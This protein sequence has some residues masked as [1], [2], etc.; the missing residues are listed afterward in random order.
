MLRRHLRLLPAVTAVLAAVAARPDPL[1]AQETAEKAAAVD[2]LLPGDVIRLR[3][4]REPDLTGEFPIA[5][6]GI[7]VLPKLGPLRATGQPPAALERKI[8]E[9]YGRYLRNPSIDVVFLRRI[10][11][12]G[13]VRQPGLF[14]VDPTMTVGDAL[15]LAGGATP[16]GK[17]DEIELLRGGEKVTVDIDE[18]TRISDL[19]IRSGDQLYVPERSWF[20]RNQGLVAALLSTTTTVLLT[21]FTYLVS[22]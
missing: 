20:V 9:M 7:V 8:I 17:P 5:A 4:W 6:D 22:Q 21:V 13:A 16:N 12:Q 2:M 15:A 11:I 18:T 3:I 14:P 1:A 19:P 10:N